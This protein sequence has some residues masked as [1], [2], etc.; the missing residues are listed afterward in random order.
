MQQTD[1]QK[2]RRSLA[3]WRT[4]RHIAERA[5]IHAHGEVGKIKAWARVTHAREEFT[6]VTLSLEA[7][8]KAA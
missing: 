4:E 6:R 1:L 2:L 8:E 5:L 7:A 3:F